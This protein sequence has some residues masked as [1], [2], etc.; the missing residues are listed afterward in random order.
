MGVTLG[1]WFLRD[2]RVAR[3]YFAV[4]TV[5]GALWWLGVFT[6]DWVR[7]A[8]L[9]GLDPLPVFC[10]DLPLFVCA[11]ALAAAGIRLAGAVAAGW[12]V[13]VAFGMTAYATVTGLAG[14][15]ALIMIAAAVGST[16][17]ALVL[18]CGRVPS[19]RLIT[20]PFAFR[21][22]RATGRTAHLWLTAAQTSVFWLVFLGV[23]PAAIS[24]LERRW[25][26]ELAAPLAV[27]IIGVALFLCGSAVGVWSAATMAS[28][29]RGTPL[30]ATMA[31]E[32]VIAGPYRFVRNP[33]ALASIAQGVAVG[34]MIGSWL[35]V[36]Y[37]IAGALVWDWLIRPHEEADLSA[38]FGEPFHRYRD[39]VR[40][41]VPTWH[42][43]AGPDSDQD[44]APR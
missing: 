37:A 32:L 43:A 44:P 34:L 31:S 20:G 13:L 9:G 29:G 15:G 28:R 3:A 30:P 24:L 25:G 16:G 22:A 14:W 19:E 4:Q 41:W 35:V 42:P 39:S 7:V 2:A 40:C 27:R 5:A 1:P 26:L 21:E 10:L 18:W 12:T 38:R 6:L 36:L 11:S 33:M 17:A 23:L 8:T